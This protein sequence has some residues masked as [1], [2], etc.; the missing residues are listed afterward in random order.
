MASIVDNYAG[1]ALQLGNEEFVRKMSFGNNWN[2]LRIGMR[3]AVNG[4]ANITAAHLQAGLCS[5]DVDT[6]A[7]PNCVQFVGSLLPSGDNTWTYSAG[8]FT[9]NTVF[10]TSTSTVTKVGSTITPT[11]QTSV[12]THYIAGTAGGTS[13]VY[14]TNIVRLSDTSVS[15]QQSITQAGAFADV[16]F[17]DFMRGMENEAGGGTAGVTV[18]GTARVISGMATTFLDT[19]SI[20]WNKSTPTIEINDLCVLR[21]Y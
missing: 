18:Y 17:Y 9:S 5:G 2:S 14:F 10:A 19:L 3:F 21:F 1:R 11:I 12:S 4:T 13:S 6:F 20:Y 8:S 7:S 15:V 16:S